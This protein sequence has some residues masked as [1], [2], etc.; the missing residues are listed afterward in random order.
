MK[1]PKKILIKFLRRGA[2][3]SIVGIL[4]G[5]SSSAVLV[6]LEWATQDRLDHLR[7]IWLLPAAGFLIR[8]VYHH[9]GKNSARGNSL[10]HDEI[11]DPKKILPFR[12][13]PL[14]LLGTLLTHLFGGS[15]GRE[16][17]AA[18]MGVSL[19]DQPPKFFKLEAGGRRLLVVAGMGAGFR[20]A[21]GTPRAGA[22]FVMNVL[23]IGKLQLS[24]WF[25][26]QIAEDWIVITN[27]E[28]YL[29][30]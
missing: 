4:A 21:I 11:H 13:A 22:I 25:Q 17:A 2:L 6:L 27:I 15:A 29:K 23:N 1:N 7:L 16:G 18:Q 10:I 28:N 8:W 19:A 9:Y 26:A 12:I 24:V 20:S 3:S 30:I 5:I 14:G